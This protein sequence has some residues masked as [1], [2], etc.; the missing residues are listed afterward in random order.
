MIETG[1]HHF[2]LVSDPREKSVHVSAR[3]MVPYWGDPENIY[4]GSFG[5]VEVSRGQTKQTMV[6]TEVEY[7]IFEEVGSVQRPQR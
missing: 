1:N 5:P 7:V 4:S 2:E 6:G 3:S